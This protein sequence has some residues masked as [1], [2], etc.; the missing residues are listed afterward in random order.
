[1]TSEV[2]YTDAALL[3][4]LTGSGTTP[5][6]V[7]TLT[8]SYLSWHIN[9]GGTFSEATHAGLDATITY[10][11]TPVPLPGAMLLF[12]PGLLGLVAVRSGL[13]RQCKIQ[14]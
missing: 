13:N 2:S 14:G 9:S 5:L 8:E 12:T 1:M 11:Y 6:S 10:D 4:L 3:A 7:S